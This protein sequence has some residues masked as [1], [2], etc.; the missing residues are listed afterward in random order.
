[1]AEAIAASA[2]IEPAPR[3]LA[4]GSDAYQFMRTALTMRLADLEAQKELA[5]STD[6]D[7]T[8]HPATAGP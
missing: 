8:R 4:L 6:A 3:R 2:D 1:M 7:D 5:H